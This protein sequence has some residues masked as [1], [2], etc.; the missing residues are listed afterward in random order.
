MAKKRTRISENLYLLR[1]DD[2]REYYTVRFTR[3]GKQRE[4]SLGPTKSI[5][6][7]QARM[8]AAAAMSEEEAA[9]VER[10]TFESILAPAIADIKRIKQW[11]NAKSEH[12]WRTTLERYAVPVIGRKTVDEITRDDIVRILEPIWET[13][14]DTASKVLQR[15]SSV[16]SWAMVRGL[17][18]EANPATWKGNLEYFFAPRAKVHKPEHHDAPTMDELRKVV[19]Y[20]RAHR[21]S[22]S[23]ILLFVI[24]TACRVS[25]ARLLTS[26]Q[27]HGTTWEVP[28][29]NQKT[30]EEGRRVPL[31]PLALEALSMGQEDGIAFP[32]LGGGLL[33][34]DTPRQK[35]M[36]ILGRK[37]TAH[38]IRSTFRDWAARA[39]IQDAVAEK[40]LSHVWGSE[41]TRAYYRTDL[42]E[43]RK[44]ALEEW[45]AC[46][47]QRP[48]RGSK[49]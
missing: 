23:G 39:N 17:R 38:G 37:T 9:P 35:L 29:E 43:E 11:R 12:Q 3:D 47:L 27:I 15:L 32:G 46:L 30:E 26:G 4:R 6:L 31:S 16:F 19:Q 7:R 34:V 18:K 45:A 24:A 40:C 36:A 22:G 2:G 42:Y 14:T 1:Y 44:A 10:A 25:E 49:V 41:V 33:A 8:R 48:A 13:K 20:C 28:A 21:N 5:S